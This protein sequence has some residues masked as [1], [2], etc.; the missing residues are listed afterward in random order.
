MSDVWA[1]TIPFRET[2]HYVQN[3]ML[4]TAIYEHRLGRETTPLSVR[5]PPITPLGASLSR[6]DADPHDGDSTGDSGSS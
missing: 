6:R 1:E 2:R 4:F 3:V 5:M